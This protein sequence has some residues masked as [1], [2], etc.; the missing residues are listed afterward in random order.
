MKLDNE[1]REMLILSVVNSAYDLNHIIPNIELILF[2]MFTSPISTKGQRKAS[3]SEDLL[4]GNLFHSLGEDFKMPKQ[5]YVSLLQSVALNPKKKHFKKILQYMVLHEKAD[6]LDAEL[7]D[8]ITFI[9][10]DQRYP[11]LL[12]STMKYFLQNDYKVRPATFQ[13]FVLFLERCKG[14]EED[15]NR[16]LFLSSDTKDIQMDYP[17]VRPLF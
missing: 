16:F 11:V 3:D 10:I 9:G 5:A 7:I 17:M 12:G 13:Q 6:Q 1:E 15:A 4:A 8:M 14:Y 2:K